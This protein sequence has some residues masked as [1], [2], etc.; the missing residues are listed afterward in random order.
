MKNVTW[1]RVAMILG[2][3]IIGM[4]AFG[5]GY[6]AGA[7]SAADFMIGTIV[8]IMGYENITIDITMPELRQY[9]LRLKGG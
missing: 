5:A 1:R 7:L 3:I 4:M 2:L 8:T 9:Y 6:S